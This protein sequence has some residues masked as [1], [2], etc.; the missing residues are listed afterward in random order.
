MVSAPL[1]KLS[2]ALRFDSD[3]V[4]GATATTATRG[5]LSIKVGG[6]QL[7][8]RE[9]S[10]GVHWPWVSLLEYL[11]DIWDRL[12]FEEGLPLGLEVASLQDVERQMDRRWAHASS[13]RQEEE[14]EVY[15]GFRFAHD[16]AEGVPGKLLPSV[17]LVREG[18]TCWVLRDDV[19]LAVD[20]EQAMA[21][22]ERVA[23]MIV[24]RLVLCDDKYASAVVA[25]WDARP[26][27]NSDEVLSSLSGLQVADLQ[28]VIGSD[29]TPA[30][31]F[32]TVK[33]SPFRNPLALA[34]RMAGTL[35]PSQ[36]A[37]VVNAVRH[38]PKS[39]TARLDIESSR[40]VEQCQFL[41]LETAYEQGY[42][43]ANWVRTYLAEWTA[44]R[45]MSPSMILEK[46]EV[47]VVEQNLGFGG[48]LAVCA[49]AG[50]VGPAILLN[51]GHRSL[52]YP[53]VRRTTLAHELCHL[54]VDRDRTLPAAEVL[55]GQVPEFVE[56]RAR[57]FAAELL[58][59]RRIAAME[60]RH[61][62]HDSDGRVRSIATRHVVSHEVVAWQ[63]RNS[64]VE[65]NQFEYNVLR[66]KV[67]QPAQF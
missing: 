16:L 24:E 65:L 22:F 9:G 23:G 57:A 66:S 11:A 21:E 50:E 33:Y 46:L 27:G 17:V 4:T 2:I 12:F 59:P 37:T 67:S 42:E 29:S 31:F 1:S 45:A 62:P 25:C 7:W 28:K 40:I 44:K 3:E 10:G 56:A 6:A 48:I 36:I 52:R 8:G 63:V 26:Q 49:W 38:L 20:V 15:E 13:D 18:L 58:L 54:L 41:S 35:G 30:T 53:S 64:T 60:W 47:P 39:T 55:G 19:V 32:E 43:L 51:M 5:W 14:G 34:A 61:L